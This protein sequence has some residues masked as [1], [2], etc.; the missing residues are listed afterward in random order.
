[1]YKNN[2]CN[3]YLFNKRFIFQV[4]TIRGKGNILRKPAHCKLHILFQDVLRK[5]V[6][7]EAVAILLLLEV[8]LQFSIE[9]FLHAFSNIYKI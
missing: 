3:S 6:R 7:G 2:C 8:L 5:V 4:D 9:I 1:M